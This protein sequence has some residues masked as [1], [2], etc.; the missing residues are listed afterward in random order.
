MFGA[1]ASPPGGESA[2][3]DVLYAVRLLAAHPAFTVTAVLTL[4]LGI[5]YRSKGK[6]HVWAHRG[7]HVLQTIH[8]MGCEIL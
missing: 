7:P 6:A 8:P 4:A 1:S 2:L 3:R 5:I